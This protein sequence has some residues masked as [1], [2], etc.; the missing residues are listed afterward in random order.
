[1][2]FLWA[3]GHSAED[4]HKEILPVHAGKCLLHKVVHNWVANVSLM[5]EVRMWLRQ[6]QKTSVLWVSTHW[7]TYGTNVSN[8]G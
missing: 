1:V 2:R 5:M 7:Y 6:H 3:E 4:I 8:V